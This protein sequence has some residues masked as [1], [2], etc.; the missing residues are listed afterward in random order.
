M[1]LFGIWVIISI[2]IVVYHT[3]LKQ[4]DSPESKGIF[5]SSKADTSRPNIILVIFDAMTARDMS[6]YGYNKVTTPFINEW[7]E[8]AS[9]FNRVESSSNWTTPATAS[10]MTGKRVWTHRTFHEYSTPVKSDIES[11]PLILKNY[12]YYNIAFVVNPY[13]S[14][15]RLG[16]ANS[17]NI[18]PP[19]LELVKSQ[20]LIGWKFGVLNV[21]LN[22]VFGDKIKF[23]TWIIDPE[24]V[25]GKI[26]TAIYYKFFV[27]F[28]TEAPPEFAF[29]KFLEIIDKGVQEPFF[30]WVHLFPPHDPYLPPEPYSGMFD[31]S[32]KL[33]S[34]NQQRG[35]L[36]E[37]KI[38]NDE[39]WGIFRARY[40]EFIRYC[41]EQFENFIEELKKRNKLKNTI[42]IF[43][44]D[45]G[46][47]FEHGDFTHG[48]THLYEQVTHVPLIIK[49]PSQIKGVIINDLVEQIDIPPTILSL[50]NIPIPPWMEGRSLMPLLHGEKLPSKLVFS[51]NFERNPGRGHQIT[52]GTIAVW[53]GDYKLI[54]YLEED[55]SLLFNLKED[56]DELKN[57][58][59]EK[60]KI[61]QHLLA[62]IQDN[63]K[64]ANESINREN[65]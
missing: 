47:S 27:I 61:S 1:W 18:A 42:I 3:W 5:Q 56:P 13:A 53:E 50:V 29:K 33:R 30:A 19:F 22:K 9:F 60:P 39:N 6:V 24:F 2:P 55:K 25:F 21:I 52:K 23:Y 12:G 63:F 37:E 35:D 44:S 54:Y 65:K 49:R 17:F 58:F 36:T 4:T 45:H 46:E 11:L 31:S 59:D 34:Y 28:Q 26:I 20:G 64:K 38:D 32:T 40:D 10:L 41:D 14:I 16:I 62:L 57:L 48:H 15:K 43:T 7:S 8:T 51:M